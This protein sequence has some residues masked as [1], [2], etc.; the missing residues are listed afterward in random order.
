MDRIQKDILKPSGFQNITVP[1]KENRAIIFDSALF[2]HTD[3]FKF[4]KGYTNRRINLTI[5]YGE[6]QQQQQQNEKRKDEL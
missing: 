6:M 2:H 4:K 1:Y 5:L 3:T